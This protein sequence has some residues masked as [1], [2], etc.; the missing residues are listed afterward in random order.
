MQCICTT[1]PFMYTLPACPCLR[2]G[3][4][5][6]SSKLRVKKKRPNKQREIRSE[7]SYTCLCQSI[8]YS[9]L[10]RNMY[11]KYS[12][13]KV[14]KRKEKTTRER[15]TIHLFLQQ[16]SYRYHFYNSSQS[17]LH[18]NTARLCPGTSAGHTTDTHTWAA[19]V[20][21]TALFFPAYAALFILYIALFSHGEV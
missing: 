8:L 9:Q 2:S 19:A 4:I 14:A 16:S 7:Q 13:P 5:Q 17:L 10:L 6:Y 21:T 11:T 15:G 18:T 12:T 3:P 20:S 1:V